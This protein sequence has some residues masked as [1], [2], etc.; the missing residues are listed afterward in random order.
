MAT[1]DLML[2][3]ATPQYFLTNH[4]RTM[5]AASFGQLQGFSLNF[6]IKL[7]VKHTSG[8]V[9]RLTHMGQTISMLFQTIPRYSLT[10]YRFN[11]FRALTSG[12]F[13]RLQSFRRIFKSTL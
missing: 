11:H 10:W 8:S 5:I 3:R 4:F 1:T 7:V 12:L 2:F 6:Y 13:N 9:L